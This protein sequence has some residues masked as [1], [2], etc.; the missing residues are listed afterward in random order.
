LI[1]LHFKDSANYATIFSIIFYRNFFN[2]EWS[3][4][5]FS[6]ENPGKNVRIRYLDSIRK[7]VRKTVVNGI[8]WLE[9]KLQNYSIS[10][11]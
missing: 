1:N 5:M 6:F 11:R 2:L 9:R 7:L 4:S 10:I 3:V 8:C